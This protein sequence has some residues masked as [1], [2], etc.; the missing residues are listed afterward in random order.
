MAG[1]LA[2]IDDKLIDALTQAKN[3]TVEEYMMQ[4]FKIEPVKGDEVHLND[5]WSLIVRD[6]DHRGRLRGVGLKN[7][8]KAESSR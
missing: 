2:G 5:T 1:S 4:H 7:K 6:V 3:Q 8:L